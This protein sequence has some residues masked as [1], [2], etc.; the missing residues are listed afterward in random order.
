VLQNIFDTTVKISYSIEICHPEFVEPSV[1]DMF[2]K[3]G[4]LRL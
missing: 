4:V 3:Y 1:E 2:G